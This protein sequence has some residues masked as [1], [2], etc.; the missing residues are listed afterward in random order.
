MAYGTPTGPADVEAFY[1]DIRR[2]RPPAPEQLADLERRYAAVG[3]TSRLAAT[4]AAQVTGVQAAL[5]ARA[6]GRYVCR[7]GAKHAD[8]KIETAVASMAADGIDTL[9]GLV[10]APHYSAGS[11]GEY[12]TRATTAAT[13]AGM[14]SA[15]IE[16]WHDNDTLISLLAAGVVAAY[17]AAGGVPADT[18]LQLLVTAHS[19][20]LRIIESGD[21]YDKRLLETAELIAAATGVAE[22]RVAWQSA[23]RTP[24]PWI[25]PDVLEVIGALPEA[26][27]TGVV[28]CPAGFTS[29]HLEV[30]YD[31]DIEAKGLAENLG[32]RFAR[33]RSLNDD[34]RLCG[35][36]ASLIEAAAPSSR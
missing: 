29:D 24:E 34:E 1:T 16:D 20:P 19:L 21:G 4:T 8:P 15:F 5:D 28:V 27:F 17:S 36:L 10:L 25:G 35:A 32:L 7:Y 11:V 30:N 12:I 18:D 14:Q 2:G 22:W 33:T 3:G 31:L 23:G 13:T 26:G 9:V 6:P